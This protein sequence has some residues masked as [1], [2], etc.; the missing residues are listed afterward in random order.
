MLEVGTG[1]GIFLPELAKH[2]N[3]LYACDIHNNYDHI[4]SLSAHYK[5][6]N[7]IVNQQNIERTTY[8]DNSF[9]AIV[10]VSV[11]EFVN[12]IQ[13][14]LNEIKRIL[15]PDGI[16]ITIC[17]MNNSFLDSIL[18]LYS[19]KKPKEEFGNSRSFV[20]KELEKSFVVISKGFML[21]IVGKWFPV[22]TH[23]K[24]S[25]NN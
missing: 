15:K 25:K 8:S 14:A 16:F 6:N 7:C 17:P 1:S 12:D 24:L 13:M 3:S 5:I 21:P 18:S 10:A 20:T 9:D 11:L 4:K 2:C 19:K 22:Y 23:Y